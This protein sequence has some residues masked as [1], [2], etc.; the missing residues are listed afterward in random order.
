MSY[1]VFTVTY[2]KLEATARSLNSIIECHKEFDQLHIY[3]N[4]ICEET[5]EYIKSFAALNRTRVYLFGNDGVNIGKAKA[6]NCMAMDC[7]VKT[8]CHIDSD[9]VVE[10]GT[11]HRG[12]SL[13]KEL[14]GGIIAAYHSGDV[15]HKYRGT[16]QRRIVHDGYITT[17]KPIRMGRGCAGGCIWL[18]AIDYFQMRGYN[19][20][21]GIYG[22]NEGSLFEKYI[23]KR[24]R[25]YVAEDIVV[26][27][28]P[29]TDKEYA[30]FKEQ[31]QQRL[32]KGEKNVEVGYYG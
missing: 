31:C 3:D 10:Q 27:H 20:D 24:D 7:V 5:R 25:I 15:R 12:A 28:P 6:M 1:F 19:E 11:F 9:M 30:D 22:G 23:H 14:G 32:R 18:N 26:H 21:R 8:M 16:S 29:E 13:L 4:S 2:N 17:I